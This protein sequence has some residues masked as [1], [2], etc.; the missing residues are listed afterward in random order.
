M[1]ADPP[2]PEIKKSHTMARAGRPWRDR[3][4]PPSG[5]VWG[6]IQGVNAYWALVAGIDLGVFDALEESGPVTSSDLAARMGVSPKHLQHLLDA[7]VTMQFL[8]QLDGIYQLTETAERYLC[9]DGAASM[10]SLVRVSPGPMENWTGLADTIRNGAAA[11]PIEDD[12]TGFYGPLDRATFAT[13]YRVATLTGFRLGWRKRPGLR[14]L[15]LGAGLGPWASAVLDQSEGSRAVVNDVP[16][17]LALAEDSFVERGLSDRVSFLPGDFHK[18][19]LEQDGFDVVALCHVCRTEGPDASPTLIK[20]AVS[21]LRPGGTLLLA[22]Y[23]ADNERRLN[24]FGVQ[25]G[26]TMLANT[27]QG[28]VLT[29]EQ[30]YNWLS[31]TPLER[32]RLVE[33]IAFNQVYTAIKKV[34]GE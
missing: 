15:D 19:P 26:L 9:T 18:V 12:F 25:M 8:E 29:H 3:K 24:P 17:I 1:G 20:R 2:Y 27:R 33:P 30:M 16:E 31:D 32:V 21:A 6:V 34:H 23:F 22:D 11:S 4:P 14:V 13:Q 10:A 5:P 7:F 28:G